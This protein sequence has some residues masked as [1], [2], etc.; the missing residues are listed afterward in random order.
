MLQN[1][2]TKTKEKNNNNNNKNVGCKKDS[3]ERLLVMI[4]VGESVKL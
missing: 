3:M 1:K 2:D 4:V